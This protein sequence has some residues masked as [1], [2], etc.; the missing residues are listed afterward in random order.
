LDPF[1]KNAVAA[2]TPPQDGVPHFPEYE[3]PVQPGAIDFT[4]NNLDQINWVPDQ[5]PVEAPE[6]QSAFPSIVD[7]LEH[8]DVST[9]IDLDFNAPIVEEP[10]LT[11]P[12]V[13][14]TALAAV[15]KDTPEYFKDSA[16][17]LLDEVAVAQGPQPIVDNTGIEQ[18][19]F[20][21]PNRVAWDQ[22]VNVA[23]Q[24]ANSRNSR[25]PD[26]FRQHLAQLQAY[27]DE[28]DSRKDAISDDEA[29]LRSRIIAFIQRHQT[30]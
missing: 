25:N 4:V 9:Q 22:F 24:M 15:F 5:P 19:T 1:E 14:Q 13:A 6:P 28:L 3:V 27:I 12:E 18:N 10:P 7:T 21:Q 2:I 23:N 8:T 11:N 29:A 16:D 26:E 20:G 17:S 30:A